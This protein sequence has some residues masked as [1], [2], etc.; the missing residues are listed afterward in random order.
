RLRMHLNHD[1]EYVVREVHPREMNYRGPAEGLFR[2]DIEL[3]LTL[4]PNEARVREA[5]RRSPAS[6]KRKRP[7]VFG[8]EV[9]EDSG[10]LSVRGKRGERAVVGVLLQG[11]YRE[12]EV[13][14]PAGDLQLHLRDCVCTER[15]L[16]Q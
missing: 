1:S 14:F 7:E 6:A 10:G 2:R 5:V 11:S 12:E 13:A 16:E 15:P 3:S 9:V 8:A 4:D